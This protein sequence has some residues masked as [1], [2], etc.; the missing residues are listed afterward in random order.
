MTK[1]NSDKSGRAAR[2]REE[3]AVKK[4]GATVAQANTTPRP[5]PTGGGMRVSIDEMTQL[6]VERD[7]TINRLK[8]QIASQQNQ[9]TELRSAQEPVEEPTEEP[10]TEEQ[11]PEEDS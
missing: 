7:I 9:I 4:A 11:L 10:T 6:I 5:V 1:P 2:R 8:Q 3:R